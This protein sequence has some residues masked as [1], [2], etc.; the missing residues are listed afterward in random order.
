[1]SYLNDVFFQFLLDEYHYNSDYGSVIND[2]HAG[3]VRLL[4]DRAF[5]NNIVSDD[6]LG[7]MSREMYTEL[8]KFTS[9]R[10]ILDKLAFEGSPERL[11]TRITQLMELMAQ[12]KYTVLPFA[13]SEH[14]VVLVFVRLG[15]SYNI[16]FC[17]SGLGAQYQTYKSNQRI[18]VDSIIMQT[19][20]KD[21]LRYFLAFTMLSQTIDEFY[22]TA[23][24]V[25]QQNSIYVENTDYNEAKGAYMLKNKLNSDLSFLEPQHVGSC[26][27]RS[28]LIPIYLYLCIL[29]TLSVER[30][31]EFIGYGRIFCT[32][33]YLKDMSVKSKL[34]Q[35]LTRP[36]EG[37][38]FNYVVDI[39]QDRERYTD[40]KV[41]KKEISDINKLISKMKVALMKYKTE[42]TAF[43]SLDGSSK[44]M[45]VTLDRPLPLNINVQDKKILN[46]C[47]IYEYLDGSNYPNSIIRRFDSFNVLLST[48]KNNQID[49]FFDE[50]AQNVQSDAYLMDIFF[51]THRMTVAEDLLNI[52]QNIVKL[53]QIPT[54][55]D[56]FAN[57]KRDR[58]TLDCNFMLLFGIVNTYCKKIAEDLKLPDSSD[59]KMLNRIMG[60]M[61]VNNITSYEKFKQS[62][63]KILTDDK[64]YVDHL[65]SGSDSFVKALF[66][67]DMKDMSAR[68]NER[69]DIKTC[70]TNYEK[71]LLTGVYIHEKNRNYLLKKIAVYIVDSILDVDLSDIYASG[72][73]KI[74]GD[75]LIGYTIR[76]W[77]TI[78]TNHS[79]SDLTAEIKTAKRRLEPDQVETLERMLKFCKIKLSV[80]IDAAFKRFIETADV[81]KENMIEMAKFDYRFDGGY[82]VSSSRS[83]YCHV[84][85]HNP[86]SK[87]EIVYTG[88]GSA[89]SL[90]TM[91]Q[92]HKTCNEYYREEHFVP[93]GVKSAFVPR[94]KL[95]KK[96]SK[97]MYDVNRSCTA[98]IE[99]RVEPRVE[100]L[101][102]EPI[103]VPKAAAKVVLGSAPVLG[104]GVKK[105]SV[106]VDDSAL[107]EG[108]AWKDHKDNKFPMTGNQRA[109]DLLYLAQGLQ[110]GETNYAA[111]YFLGYFDRMYKKIPTAWKRG[112]VTSEM[113]ED[114][115]RGL[116]Y[117]TM[118]DT[119]YHKLAIKAKILDPEIVRIGSQMMIDTFSKMVRSLEGKPY[120]PKSINSVK[121]RNDTIN[122]IK[123][124]IAAK[125]VEEEVPDVEVVEELPVVLPKRELPMKE[126]LD[127][128]MISLID[129]LVVDDQQNNG[130]VKAT[131]VVTNDIFAHIKELLKQYTAKENIKLTYN[132]GDGVKDDKDDVRD[133]S[134]L[135]TETMVR[136]RNKIEK[137]YRED[138]SDLMDRLLP[139]NRMNISA[140]ALRYCYANTFYVSFV[141][142]IKPFA[143]VKNVL[144]KLMYSK[145]KLVTD[146]STQYVLP[147]ICRDILVNPYG[148]LKDI[149]NTANVFPNVYM[150][151]KSIIAKKDAV[152]RIIGLEYDYHNHQ[153]KLVQM[154]HEEIEI[155]DLVAFATTI[156][157][158]KLT[159]DVL[160][161]EK[162]LYLV[163]CYL[164]YL[165]NTIKYD[166]PVDE[167]KYAAYLKV[168][169]VI[170]TYTK[171]KNYETMM[172]MSAYMIDYLDFK[173]NIAKKTPKKMNPMIAKL[174][175]YDLTEFIKG[176]NDT[177]IIEEG[178]IYDL[179]QA[180]SVTD[181][182]FESELLD[183]YSSTVYLRDY[184]SDTVVARLVNK[185]EFNRNAKSKIIGGKVIFTS[186]DQSI[187]ISHRSRDGANLDNAA[188]FF[189][190]YSRPNMAALGLQNFYNVDA[191]TRYVVSL[192]GKRVLVP[193]EIQGIPLCLIDHMILCVDDASKITAIGYDT[194][195][196]DSQDNKILIDKTASNISA[197]LTVDAGMIMKMKI[198]LG[199]TEYD[200]VPDIAKI[201]QNIM[202]QLSIDHMDM[203]DGALILKLET[204]YYLFLQRMGIRIKISDTDLTV[205]QT[206]GSVLT[207][208][209]MT[210]TNDMKMLN[211]EERSKYLLGS[212]KNILLC[213]SAADL[214]HMTMYL[215]SISQDD[216]P[217]RLTKVVSSDNGM[218]KTLPDKIKLTESVMFDRYLRVQNL[219]RKLD[220][221]SLTV[222]G[223]EVLARSQRSES[224]GYILF[225]STDSLST[226]FRLYHSSIGY[227]NY[228]MTKM[229]FSYLAKVATM[230]NVAQYI[231]YLSG[232]FPYNKLFILTNDMLKEMKESTYQMISLIILNRKL[233]SSMR[234]KKGFFNK[235]NT[236]NMDFRMV[237]EAIPYVGMCDVKDNSTR[238]DKVKTMLIDMRR[239][240]RG[241]DYP[242]ISLRKYLDDPDS[243]GSILLNY[244]CRSL[245]RTITSSFYV[246][247]DNQL[248]SSHQMN[249]IVFGGFAH[250]LGSEQP[251]TKKQEQFNMMHQMTDIGRELRW[252]IMMFKAKD[253]ILDFLVS[254]KKTFRGITPKTLA[255]ENAELLETLHV[256]SVP[257][258]KAKAKSSPKVQEASDVDDAVEDV[259]LE[260]ADVVAESVDESSEPDEVDKTIYNYCNKFMNGTETYTVEH[261]VN[262]REDCSAYLTELITKI[263]AH[264][265]KS[266]KKDIVALSEIIDNLDNVEMAEIVFFN[267]L[268]IKY[269]A[270]LLRLTSPKYD[271]KSNIDLFMQMLREY[272]GYIDE[273]GHIE[274]NTLV[275][276][277]DYV[278]SLT[279]GS[280]DPLKGGTVIRR[281][282]YKLINRIIDSDCNVS[283]RNKFHQMIMGAG[284]STYIAPLLSLL[285]TANGMFP[286]HCMPEYLIE[287]SVERMGLLQYF[288]ITNVR[289][290]IGRQD[291]KSD[292][293]CLDEISLNGIN[294]QAVNLIMSDQSLK[295]ILLNNAQYGD[296]TVIR[297]LLTKL[298]SSYLIF[299]EVDDISD[300]YSC[301]LNYP[302]PHSTLDIEM[303]ERRFQLH[304]SIMKYFYVVEIRELYKI[305]QFPYESIKYDPL[306]IEPT[307]I[308][309]DRELTKGM[310]REMYE[311]RK[312][313]FTTEL[314][315]FLGLDQNSELDRELIIDFSED[316]NIDALVNYDDFIKM[317]KEFIRTIDESV[318]LTEEYGTSKQDFIK[319][320]ELIRSL[321][322]D[323]IPYCL[324]T[325]NRKD[326]GLI[327]TKG[328]SRDH[329]GHTIAI[330]FKALE[331]PNFKSEFSSIDIT[332]ALTVVSYMSNPYILR[333]GDYDMILDDL[334]SAHKQMD[335]QEWTISDTKAEYIDTCSSILRFEAPPD[336]DISKL[337]TFD[338]VMAFKDVYAGAKVP[339]DMNTNIKL[340]D[341]MIQTSA[342]KYMKEYTYQLSSTFSDVASSDFCPNR[343]GFSGTP[344]FVAPLDRN[345]KKILDVDPQKDEFAEGQ[346]YYS[347]LDK[348]VEII[349]I[350]REAVL[351]EHDRA[352]SPVD[353]IMII[354]RNAKYYA[355]I[356][357]G[358]YF[359][360]MTSE[361]VSQML[362]KLDHVDH[363]LYL[364]KDDRQVI[365]SKVDLPRV[366]VRAEKDV[367]IK[368]RE[369]LFVYYD[370]KHITGIDVKKMHLQAKGLVLLRY[371]NQL[372]DYSQGA[373]RLR[374]INITQSVD[375]VVDRTIIKKAR[376]EP[377]DSQDVWK[378]KLLRH[379]IRGQNNLT[380]Q[381][382][383]MQS[384]HNIRT[385][386][387]YAF[388]NRDVSRL[389]YSLINDDMRRNVFMVRN[390]FGLPKRIEDVVQ[391]PI[392]YVIRSLDGLVIQI[393]ELDNNIRLKQNVINLA[394]VVQKII[395]S[396]RMDS[397]QVNMN[398]MEEVAEEVQEEQI[399]EE[400]EEIFQQIMMQLRK[401]YAGFTDI[402]QSYPIDDI[403][404][405]SSVQTI[406]DPTAFKKTFVTYGYDNV[407]LISSLFISRFYAMTYEYL[408][409]NRIEFQYRMIWHIKLKKLIIVLPEEFLQIRNV[410]GRLIEKDI[411]LKDILDFDVKCGALDEGMISLMRY[412]LDFVLNMRNDQIAMID[413][414][415]TDFP[416]F[417][418]YSYVYSRADDVR[419]KKQ[420]KIVDR[421]ILK[422]VL[423]KQF[424]PI[425]MDAEGTTLLIRHIVAISKLKK[426]DERIRYIAQLHDA[427][428]K[429]LRILLVER[430][431]IANYMTMGLKELL[432]RE[433]SWKYVQIYQMMLQSYLEYIS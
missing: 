246:V 199:G 258:V 16:Y 390:S 109:I 235:I 407:I 272:P 83:R 145:N 383:Q 406:S 117:D 168:L 308:Y 344:Y 226:A 365:I 147:S 119:E 106:V 150:L 254:D 156:E 134:R 101:R 206:H 363:V 428:P 277:F 153:D 275:V 280:K 19:V 111:H 281:K 24:N 301:E 351:V 261:L 339:I 22:K 279:E 46:R 53:I 257:V 382:E 412:Q 333:K 95:N 88:Y 379:L 237:R 233:P 195:S 193:Y 184:A 82:A 183:Y 263:E 364:D 253:G 249:D 413:K 349:P 245:D 121:L 312:V 404:D 409:T 393:V 182:S 48:I 323:V 394:K 241:V 422:F 130:P 297:K 55:D 386:C 23:L 28:I 255:T 358:A 84:S 185:Y 174:I 13:R 159:Q 207:V 180:N 243:I 374:K 108:G 306:M 432:L 205:V 77:I 137:S 208:D 57:I 389:E 388:L 98:P 310:I 216:K 158:W 124:M 338:K 295:A 325:R 15:T 103:I 40:N 315:Q 31:D 356:D 71:K 44:D 45:I 331:D 7:L 25:A 417:K 224:D 248:L 210:A 298:R 269:K 352:V 163:M 172:G 66:P 105:D 231:D 366:V 289:Q 35:I 110:A 63:E 287:Q 125:Y 329:K 141:S 400:D 191:N 97:P 116:D 396:R 47:N 42:Q 6:L 408:L 131:D 54:A 328:Y 17:N 340:F 397:Q 335:E 367:Q 187:T 112:N 336:I 229:A 157:S 291:M 283:A 411:A 327:D 319:R 8:K 204:N 162:K 282:Q 238:L 175:S 290:Q 178:I 115:L 236:D 372:R 421:T 303:L 102:G 294:N 164:F 410:Y 433:I 58:Y 292:I 218:W 34:E 268:L 139:E 39:F 239:R 126:Y 322:H 169:T 56:L 41:I 398:I 212:Q 211:C 1:M 142:S 70:I 215:S 37:T 250:R 12:D 107:Q 371:T 76:N 203:P 318:P 256:A 244:L 64:L 222:P 197:T 273:D 225:D 326:F 429:F 284:K 20:T 293:Y 320:F 342:K 129:P 146:I 135:Q 307:L 430:F 213:G 85:I 252:D 138:V 5:E 427:M 192:N 38:F 405:L 99:P 62:V 347:I 311:A 80:L 144:E 151:Q 296:M 423:G 392:Q 81:M 264:L 166:A 149:I 418:T 314:N 209:L 36:A 127:E 181:N 200:I 251:V 189:T 214:D 361:Q 240:E 61:V 4:A 337:Y 155:D 370:Q 223:I 202:S 186:G 123:N 234:F 380:S 152:N 217:F 424:V 170:S 179:L 122:L 302:D 86:V 300:P 78:C 221:L 196:T 309:I 67:G 414:Y 90:Q 375:I 341:N 271:V 74:S 345:S 165:I 188:N 143:A 29:N 304:S 402:N 359:L 52:I 425:K 89:T 27:F 419:A 132:L 11:G 65:I 355:L 395:V 360:G 267:T 100:P 299:D 2:H 220:K 51:T 49:W 128:K 276:Y 161:I 387:R 227:A 9:T 247:F 431:N 3:L 385:I 348:R 113:I 91:K 75:M 232:S 198:R 173:Y 330:P 230:S 68:E 136:N 373:F 18:N 93:I 140:H 10:I 94:Y 357:I 114:F 201:Y 288:G 316:E 228:P 420:F 96:S 154:F 26:S 79:E 368:D 177:V 32:A 391:D 242:S 176:E 378:G 43:S 334:S 118:L 270:D 60:P 416:I 278:F 265:R 171:A 92:F 415:I 403:L 376:L 362:L 354:L 21:V 426:P 343:T 219:S 167:S 69:F 350:A 346:I 324:V 401:M 33:K 321:F 148:E 72:K 399:E 305:K 260:K 274:V 194:E 286:I 120:D 285:L 87:N 262:F 369:K 73:E 50:L 160:N 133:R 377:T 190:S 313:Q 266:Y 104:T 332:I 59:Y 353:A 259:D 317:V 14:A 384:L 381:K 30:F